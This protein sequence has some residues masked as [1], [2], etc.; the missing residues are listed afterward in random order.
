MKKKVKNAIL[1][2]ITFTALILWILSILAIDSTTKIP[3]CT[4]VL[5]TGWLFAFM[6]AN[7]WMDN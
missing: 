3:F 1:Y 7:G 5:T 6:W 2:T 4:L